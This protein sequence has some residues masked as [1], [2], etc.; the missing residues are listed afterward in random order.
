M[1][2]QNIRHTF[3]MSWMSIRPWLVSWAGCDVH[4]GL[5]VKKRNDIEAEE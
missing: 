4:R 1:V 3:I 2:M 5:D